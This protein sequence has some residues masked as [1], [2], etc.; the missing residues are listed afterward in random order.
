[1]RYG[2][3]ALGALMDEYER[4]MNEYVGVLAKVPQD[5]YAAILD[6]T[7]SDPD[8]VSIER[9]AYHTLWAG[10]AYAN[11]IRTAFGI[12]HKTPERFVPTQ[13]SVAGDMADMLH[14]TEV[15]FE[16]RWD[17]PDEVLTATNIPVRWSDHHDLEAILE[18]AIVHI[19]RHRRQVEFLL[20]Q[21]KTNGIAM[22]AEIGQASSA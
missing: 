8:C 3:H 16:G 21:S 1:M 7:T 20:A 6:P 5:L 19:L 10:Y 12:A 15:A 9:I 18:H 13:Q 14:Y 4:A 17:M 22:P 11:G 2:K